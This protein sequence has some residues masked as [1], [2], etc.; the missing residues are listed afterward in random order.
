MGIQRSIN[1]KKRYE[2]IAGDQAP[3]YTPEDLNYLKISNPKVFEVP[4][5]TLI[6][7]NTYGVH[8]RIKSIRPSANRL[9]IFSIIRPNPFNLLPGWGM[10]IHSYFNMIFLN[11]IDPNSLIYRYFKPK[12]HV[13]FK[14]GGIRK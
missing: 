11:F 12:K 10:K 9:E 2:N 7:A 13:A 14:N 1:H 6:I 3:R 4:K 5:N 8:S